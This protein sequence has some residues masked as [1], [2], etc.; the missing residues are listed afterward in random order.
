MDVKILVIHIPTDLGL[1]KK[2]KLSN[3]SVFSRYVKSMNF[4]TPV[5]WCMTRTSPG[6]QGEV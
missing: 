4:P 2:N 6:F 3:E 1:L 5:R